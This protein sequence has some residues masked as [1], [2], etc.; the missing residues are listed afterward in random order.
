MSAPRHHQAKAPTGSPELSIRPL[1]RSTLGFVLVSALALGGPAYGAPPRDEGI[2]VQQFRPGGGASDYLHLQGGFMGRHTGFT[3]GTVFDNADVVLLTDRKGDGVKSGIVDGQATLNLM[4]SFGLWERLELGIAMPLVLSQT[5]GPAWPFLMPGDPA[6]DGF[7]LADLRI[8][9]KVKIVDGGK[10]FALAIAAPISI[11]IGSSFAGYGTLSVEPKIIL[12]WNPAYYFRLTMNVGGRFRDAT[13]FDG[14]QLGEEVTWGLGM[15][16]SFFLGDQLFSVL[17]SFA[18]SFELPDQTLE[19]PP[20]EFLGGL[21]WRGIQ[22]LAVYAAAGAGLTRGYGSPDLRGVVGIRIGGYRDC[23]HGDEDFDGFEDDDNCADLDNDRDGV[24]DVLDQCPNEP[25]AKNGWDDDDGCPDVPLA[26]ATV[27]DGREDPNALSR[28]SDGDGIPDAFDHC[29]DLA[30]DLDGFEDGDGCPEGDND[31]DGV[32]D[33]ADRCP[34][35]AEVLNGFEDSDGCPDSPTGPVRVDDLARTITIT[36][37]IYFDTG[38]ATIQARSFA[39][40]D[41]IAALLDTRKDIKRLRIEGHTDNV[42]SAALN[43]RLSSE[44]AASVA[45]YLVDKGIAADR[46]ESRGIGKEEPIAD[47]RTVKGRAENRRVEFEI[48][49]YEGSTAPLEAVPVNDIPIPE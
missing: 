30:E 47:N 48:V 14:L 42:G 40:I 45:K 20:F 22:D 29:P 1:L 18:G 7:H 25:E 41:A 15:K 38:K 35:L 10:Q 26:F 33:V 17:T 11:P 16:L 32:L 9:P 3:F 28:D 36:D 46:F 44:R 34:T 12:D 4:A 49:E 39:L 5:I 31:G 2:D 13:A 27:L 37:K 43:L 6:P 24:V 8:T 21:E 23:P 19:D